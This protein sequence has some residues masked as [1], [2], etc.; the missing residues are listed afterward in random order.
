MEAPATTNQGGGGGWLKGG[1]DARFKGFV[2]W[3]GRLSGEGNAS[4]QQGFGIITST[5]LRKLNGGKRFLGTV[6]YPLI[7]NPFE[8]RLKPAK[9]WY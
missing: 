8:M 6:T 3:S 9:G 7:L 2:P 4:G 5:R 1:Y